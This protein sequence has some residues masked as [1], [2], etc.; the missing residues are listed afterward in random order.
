MRHRLDLEE[1]ADDGGTGGNPMLVRRRL[2]QDD[3]KIDSGTSLCCFN[4]ATLK[5]NLRSFA[6]LAFTTI[7]LLLTVAIFTAIAI[8]TSV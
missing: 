6:K 8:K 1:E 4:R 7:D 5:D 3:A 2:D